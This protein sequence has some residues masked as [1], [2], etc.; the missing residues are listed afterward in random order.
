M[1][2]VESMGGVWVLVLILGIVAVRW[3]LAIGRL[4]P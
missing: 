1:G 3:L 2:E 4:L